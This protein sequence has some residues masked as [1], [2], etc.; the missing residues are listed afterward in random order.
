MLTYFEN[1]PVTI[2]GTGIYATSASLS[3][4]IA[5]ENIKALGL[6]NITVVGSEPP[7]GSF[8]A[9]FVIHDNDIIAKMTGF[10]DSSSFF[11]CVAGPYTANDCLFTSFGISADPNSIITASFEAEVFGEI[12]TG[13]APAQSGAAVTGAHSATMSADFS[14]VGY[15]NEAF[16]FSYDL[17]QTYILIY[18]LTGG[19][20][21]MIKEVEGGDE[22]MSVGGAGIGKALTGVN[23]VV[24]LD[25]VGDMSVSFDDGCGAPRGSLSISGYL[26]SRD[27]SISE[28][29]IVQGTVSVTQPF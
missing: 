12:V 10:R 13:T 3:Q 27:I 29:D 17:N 25:Q 24:C 15:S 5:T 2:D 21:P 7:K 1:C 18:S 23:G 19:F 14:T 16:S 4:S 28:N 9:D 8:S 22:S 11:T 6:S 26:T 20:V